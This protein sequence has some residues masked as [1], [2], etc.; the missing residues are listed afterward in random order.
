VAWEENSEGR[1]PPMAKPFR[2]LLENL[3]KER[4]RRIEDEK[5]KILHELTLKELRQA[6]DLTQQELAKTLH[7]NQAAISKMESQSD[8]Y[9]S[10]LRRVLEAMGGTLR[11]VAEFPGGGVVIDQFRRR[12]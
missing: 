1:I 9:I 7:I 11:I 3:P 10:T 6:L 5:R 8:M 2:K 4:R 12:D